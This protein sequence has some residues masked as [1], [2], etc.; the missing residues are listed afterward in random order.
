DSGNSSDLMLI[1]ALM[2]RQDFPAAMAAL[3]KLAPKMKD[4]GVPDA[5]RG[6]IHLVRKDNAAAQTAF[7]AALKADA[8]FLP[9]VLGL[10]SLDL[11]AQRNDAEV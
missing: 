5:L 1:N 11:Q 2:R 7:E 10:V 3:D 4:S 8:G 6:R 9:A